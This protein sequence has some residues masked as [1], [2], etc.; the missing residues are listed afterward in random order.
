MLVSI[1][2]WAQGFEDFQYEI[3]LS[4]VFF[5]SVGV[6]NGFSELGINS[7]SI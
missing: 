4:F 3:V 7:R 6:E 1:K 5:H 2:L